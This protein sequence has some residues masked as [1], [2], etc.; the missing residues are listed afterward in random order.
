MHNLKSSWPFKIKIKIKICK[1]SPLV[2]CRPEETTRLGGEFLLAEMRESTKD[3]LYK[4]KQ[5]AQ[6]NPDYASAIEKRVSREGFKLPSGPANSRSS[7][8]GSSSA[9]SVTSKGSGQD[10]GATS[11]GKSKVM[12]GAPSSVVKMEFK[13][14]WWPPECVIV[15]VICELSILILFLRRHHAKASPHANLELELHKLVVNML[16]TAATFQESCQ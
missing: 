15:D 9:G 6:D 3:V 8:S 5:L 12:Q 10:H 11:K 7:I 2:Q 1:C 14:T 13:G 4:L 16:N